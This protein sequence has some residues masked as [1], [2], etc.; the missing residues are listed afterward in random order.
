[1]KLVKIFGFLISIGLLGF[2]SCESDSPTPI[3]ET[4][5]APYVTTPYEVETPL[6][7]PRM[8]IPDDN[9]M[10]VE[11]VALGR[12]LFY[13]KIM[14]KDSARTCA[15]CHIQSEG[16]QTDGG[17]NQ[18]LSHINFAWSNNYMWDGHFN[19]TLEEVMIFEVEHFFETNLDRLNN[20][21][22]Y[23]DLFKKAFGVD[24]ISAKE[25]GYAL[26]QF[27]RIMTSGNAKVDRYFRGELMLDPQELRGMELF[28]TEEA[29]CFHCH[30]TALFT[31]NTPRNNGLDLNPD[32]GLF[33]VTGDPKDLGRFKT[34]TLR[35][36]ALTA[37]Y[38]HDGRFA[39]LEEVV[40]FYSSGVHN[41]ATTDPL[42]VY[43]YNGGVQ[44]SAEDQAAVVAYLKTLTDTDFINNSELSDPFE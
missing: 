28:N 6:G 30:G 23:K 11:G 16:F 24:T 41:T 21:E 4:E 29:D 5:D 37:P 44:L 12:M 19:G 18:V 38:M 39:T 17:A 36:I 3:D 2:M 20:N 34:P 32:D 9:P 31:D 7:F 43:A 33:G 40:E 1:M 13:D 25:A 42:M 35:N 10:T 27:E 8:I 15:S 22:K 26:A 14:D